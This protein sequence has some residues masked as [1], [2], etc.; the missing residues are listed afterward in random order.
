MSEGKNLLE[1]NE[2]ALREKM[3]GIA[4]ELVALKKEYYGNAK[5][6]CSLF[7][8]VCTE[9]VTLFKTIIKEEILSRFFK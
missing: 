5:K 2:V 3:V 4:E 6:V 9:D 1:M 7:E 8:D